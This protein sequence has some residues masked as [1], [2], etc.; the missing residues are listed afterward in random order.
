MYNELEHNFPLLKTHNLLVNS[1]TS[2][3]VLYD[4]EFNIK[5]L[6]V[7]SFNYK[8]LSSKLFI[9]SYVEKSP[10]ILEKIIRQGKI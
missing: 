3:R 1:F 6:Y 5:H 7:I 2:Y 10:V 9:Y 8:G 4:L